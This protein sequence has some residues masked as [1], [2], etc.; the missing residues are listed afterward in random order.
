MQVT[1]EQFPH[2]SGKKNYYITVKNFDKKFLEDEAVM[3]EVA[4]NRKHAEACGDPLDCDVF[5]STC[6]G[7]YVVAKKIVEK[8]FKVK[9]P[10]LKSMHFGKNNRVYG[11]T[12]TL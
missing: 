3:V 6:M 12:Y 8:H 9:L 11:A 1:I 2:Y 5:V 7:S 4:K 10:T